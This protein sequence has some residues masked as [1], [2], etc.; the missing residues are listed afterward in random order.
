MVMENILLCILKVQVLRLLNLTSL[1]T[2]IERSYVSG[3]NRSIRCKNKNAKFI[4]YCVKTA[5]SIKPGS[6]C[7]MTIFA[8]SVVVAPKRWSCV[9]Q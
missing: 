6:D 3:S 4:C 5:D 8:I 2:I 9:I 1:T 7:T